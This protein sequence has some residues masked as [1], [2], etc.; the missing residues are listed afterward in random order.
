MVVDMVERSRA[1]GLTRTGRSDLT[2]VLGRGRRLV[3]VEDAAATLEVTRP[4][5]ARRLAEWASR[6][7]LRRAIRGVYIPVPVDAERPGDW[8]EDPFYL[9]AAL[10]KPSFVT[11]WSAANHWGL[12][13]QVFRT[14][15]VK[16]AQRVRRSAVTAAGQDFLLV[17]AAEGE[18]GWGVRTEWRE[19]LRVPVADPARTV[20]DV[21][22]KPA[23]GGGIRLI[24]EILDS[25]LDDGDPQEL[26]AHA[27]RLGN[28]AVFKRL[29]FLVETLGLDQP[30]LVEACAARRSAGVVLLDPSV[31]GGGG[32]R[33]ARWGLRA[34]VNL[35]RAA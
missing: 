23:L 18:F 34:N 1:A 20:I 15:V 29:G 26:V 33:V 19:D 24:A 7:W 25:Y 6:G 30:E 2:R 31:D 5:A 17:H 16:T 22:D 4:E 14:T 32:S 9:A 35:D 3:T 28:R 21:L 27:E 8:T 11:G 10:W 13:D 12:T